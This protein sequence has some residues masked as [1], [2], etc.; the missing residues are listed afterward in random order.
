MR[1][2]QNPSPIPSPENLKTL[3]KRGQKNHY[4][5]NYT[6]LMVRVKRLEGKQKYHDRM[7][8]LIVPQSIQKMVNGMG[9]QNAKD[10]F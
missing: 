9:L 3:D 2:L 8:W 4:K 1:M 6:R 10:I 5:G 7:R